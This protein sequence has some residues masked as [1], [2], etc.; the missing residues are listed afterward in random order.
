MK[1][2]LRVLRYLA[3]SRGIIVLVFFVSIL[4]SLFSVVS[5]YSVLPL[6][7]A[8]FTADKT[9][10]APV[11]AGSEGRALS[12]SGLSIGGGVQGGS[13]STFIDTKALQQQ[14]TDVFQ[15]LF[16]AETKQQMLLNI[17]LFLIVTFALKN[18][19]LYLNKQLIF[20]IQTKSTKRLRDDVFHTIIEMHLDYF[21]HQRVG[22]LM[23]HVYN[24]VGS[25][26]S[27]ISATFI[28]FIQ[29]PFTIFVYIGILLVLS[30][31][32]TLFAFAVSMIIFFVIT[33]I[34]KRVKA[35]SRI[36]RQQMGNMNSVLQE[37]F[38]GIKVIKSTGFE[39]V[40]VERFKSFTNDF[41]RLDLKVY[42]LKNIISPLN[43]TLLVTAVAMVLWFGGLQ[44]FEGNMTANELIVFAFSLYS[45]MGP[46]KTL[47]E[48]NTSIQSGLV[49]AE[50][51]FELIDAE[52]LVKN[53][54]RDISGFSDVIRF[55]N[56]SFKYRR[57]DGAAKVLDGVSFEIHKGELVALVGQSGSGK[58]TAVD[59]LLR[60]YD[61]DAG[62]ITID[63]VDIREFDYKQ[64]RSMIGVVSQ[65]VI[66]F[67]D[68][69][70][71]NIAY[72]VQNGV[73]HER[74]EQA[75]RLANAHGFIEEKPDKYETVVGDRGVQLS[76]GQ[77]QRLAIARAMVRNPDLLIFDEATSALDNESEKV[78]QDAIDNALSDRT[79]LVVAHRLS[80]VK[81]ADR[82]I[83]MD[84]GRVAESGTHEELLAKNGLYKMYYNIQ[85]TSRAE[86]VSS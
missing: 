65:E 1:L 55:E 23:N 47:G 73:T 18:L 80:T 39:D 6:L 67:N 72:G 28:N 9:V 63:G 40:E 10:G 82:I 13:K 36:I 84:K 54:T 49:S 5:I 2:I 78:V 4:T 35:L 41:R 62:R 37:K 70:E 48:A 85:F 34:G 46:L 43:E 12:G 74:V 26:Q 38:N 76:G 27:S 71:Q 75:A 24:D 83:V 68:T 29:N 7:N 51:L 50:R 52:P 33:R 15:R 31:K 20:R 86:E 61:V 30:W 79:A 11:T 44:V 53:G 60:F 69:I 66:L 19:F 59:L 56:I 77:R 14:V 16:H 64:L 8:I 22:G 3:P 81:N 32:L 25:V 58:S 45:A 17:C 42:R 21:N 57:E